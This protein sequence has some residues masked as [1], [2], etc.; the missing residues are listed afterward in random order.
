MFVGTVNIYSKIVMLVIILVCILKTF[1]FMRILTMFSHLV[2]RVI[3]VMH[4]ITNFMLFFAMLITLFSAI[5][6]VIG[7]NQQE[8]YKTIGFFFASM[9][10]ALRLSIGDF[11]FDL[12]K[13]APEE[14]EKYQ[15]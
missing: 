12:L 15:S 6:N 11:N 14:I 9:F 4:K 5:F 10:Y 1:F 13:T 2:K 7:R 8:E 3:Y